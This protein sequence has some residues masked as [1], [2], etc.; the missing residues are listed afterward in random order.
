MIYAMPHVRIYESLVHR[1]SY[2]YK[3]GTTSDITKL[4]VVPLNAGVD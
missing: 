1:D 4:F 2:D 3:E